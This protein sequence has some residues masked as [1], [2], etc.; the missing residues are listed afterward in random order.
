MSTDTILDCKFKKLLVTGFDAC[1][2][3]ICTV[4]EAIELK[5]LEVSVIPVIG[6]ENIYELTSKYLKSIN[7]NYEIFDEKDMKNLINLLAE[8]YTKNIIRTNS[9]C[10]YNYAFSFENVFEDKATS[11]ILIKNGDYYIDFSF[12]RVYTF[13]K[14]KFNFISDI[15][16]AIK[17][18]II[19]YE[20][21]NEISI[22]MNYKQVIKEKRKIIK[23]L[24][25]SK[26]LRTTSKEEFDELIIDEVDAYIPE[27]DYEN[28]CIIENMYQQADSDEESVIDN[29]FYYLDNFDFEKA[30]KLLE[31]FKNIMEMKKDNGK[32]I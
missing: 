17:N 21:M 11:F 6:I 2:E 1:C 29:F 15:Y 14:N 28:D 19:S 27:I 7:E 31:N 23:R 16:T 26:D 18:N 10:Q 22:F 13:S 24:K 9:W 30:K 32:I 3:G 20:D 25:S 12:E 4:K 8:E 5:D